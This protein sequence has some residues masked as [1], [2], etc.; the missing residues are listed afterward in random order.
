MVIG[1]YGIESPLPYVHNFK[2]STFFN[3]SSV[4]NSN[5]S[6]NN[7]VV[8]GSLTMCSSTSLVKKTMWKSSQGMA[9]CLLH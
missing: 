3:S 8:L 1:Y 4:R 2:N 7:G 5:Q 9:Y 6:L